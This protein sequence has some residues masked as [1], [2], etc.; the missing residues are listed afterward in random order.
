MVREQPA[1]Y[2]AFDLLA[3]DGRS[4]LDA[5]LTQ[6]RARLVELLAGAPPQLMLCPQTED[7]RLVDEWL[8]TWTAAGVEGVL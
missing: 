2:V 1:H 4:L 6:R 3:A 7:R 8:T 5:P